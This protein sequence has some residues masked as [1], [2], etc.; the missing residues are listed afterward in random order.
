MTDKESIN[1]NLE[2]IF[3]AVGIKVG[4]QNYTYYTA[5]EAHSGEN[6]YGILQAPRG[7]ATEAIVLVAAWTSIDGQPNRNGVALALTLARYFKRLSYYLAAPRCNFAYDSYRMVA[8]VQRYYH[9]T[10]PRQPNRSA[11]LGRCLPRCP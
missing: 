4:R 11:G 9:F 5:G 1:D 10:T 3:R 8:L 7:D 2:A 6:L